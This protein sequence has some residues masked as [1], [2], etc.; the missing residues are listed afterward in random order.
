MQLTIFTN[1][2]YPIVWTAMQDP[3]P[4]NASMYPIV[5]ARLLVKDFEG[6]GK[7]KP[8]IQIDEMK[9]FIPDTEEAAEVD[10]AIKSAIDKLVGE[11]TDNFGAFIFCI[12]GE[13]FQSFTFP[14]DGKL[15]VMLTPYVDR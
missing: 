15:G 8:Y 13:F 14:K 11:I 10:A 12:N 1:S 4:E 9:K 7:R 5:H 6:S 2:E 3:R